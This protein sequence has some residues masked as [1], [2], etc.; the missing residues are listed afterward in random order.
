MADELTQ[1]ER[2]VVAGEI[3]AELIWPGAPTPTV[4]AAAAALNVR[5][6]QILK[7]LVF[8]NG[9][10]AVLAIACGL[11]RVSV[12][13]LGAF[14]GFA[15]LKLAKPPE[16]LE[17]TGYPVGAMPPVALRNPLPVIVDVRVAALEVAIAGGGRIDALL[18][19]T[20]AEILRVTGAKVADIVE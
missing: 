3:A 10:Q 2:A 16:V 20:P 7:S 12:A 17:R 4:Q 11:S 9:A 15:G 1:V 18:R 14:T 5:E 13:K 8:T 19:I 6:D